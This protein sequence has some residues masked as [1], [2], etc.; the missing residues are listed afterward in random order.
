MMSID[1]AIPTKS[2]TLSRVWEPLELGHLTLK[3]RMIVPARTLDWGKDGVLS[4]RHLDV[5][6]E[7]AKGGPSLI[8]TEQHAAYKVAKGSFP[9][10][11][12]AWEYSAIP[13]FEKMAESLHKE[14]V[15]GLVQLFG[16]GA[17]DKGSMLFDEWHE[18]WGVSEIPS[19]VHFEQPM[20]ME[21]RHI[22]TVVEGFARSAVNVMNGGLD[23]VE[24]HAAHSYLLAQFLTGS[25]NTRTDEYGGSLKNRARIHLEI[26]ERIREEVGDKIVVGF[27]MSYSE[28]LGE[29]GITPEES[30]EVLS[31]LNESGLFDYFSI[32][33]GSYYTLNKA[34]VPMGVG[35]PEGLLV[36]YAAR[37]KRIVGDDA[38]IITVGRIR[39]L[40]LAEGILE[41]GAADLV[42]MGRAQLADPHIVRKTKEGR[43]REIIKCVGMNECV[44]RVF[45]FK[46]VLCAMNPA[47][48]REA[49]WGSGTLDTVATPRKI[50]VVGAGPSGMKFAAVAASRGH[51]VTL[52]EKSDELGGHLKLLT[53]FPNLKDWDRAIDNL[54]REVQNHNVT[55]RL[56]TEVSVDDLKSG[57]Q[58]LVVFATGS[59]YSQTGHTPI[60]PG[61]PS[62]PGH[63]DERVITIDNAAERVLE[64]PKGLGERVILVDESGNDLPIN[65]ALIAAEAG[66]KV[67]IVTPKKFVGQNVER[68][69]QTAAWFPRLKAAGV[70]FVSEHMVTNIEQGGRVTVSDLYGGSKEEEGVTTIVLSQYRDPQLRLYKALIDEEQSFDIERVGDCLAPRDFAGIMY[71]GVQ[72]GRSV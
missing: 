1:T 34:M 22:R 69:L 71:D 55:V 70:E 35:D 62:I 11:V 42:A 39:D 32:S 5:F 53:R 65:V 61:V 64:N 43:E 9:N 58:D 23:G 14:D 54:T 59:R 67:T 45:D 16:P 56:G 17:H 51:Q 4:Q 31:I 27:R 19:L 47:T 20:V 8:L 38:K 28:F 37:A 63:E 36:P 7:L 25:H 24:L 18:L 13:Q 6:E 33:G 2:E 40:Y 26:G 30:D 50:T 29:A 12:S 44:G 68:H 46:E 41:S 66:S 21:K 10:P 52:F 60:L 49:R 72:L 3:N 48:G 15:A 57:D